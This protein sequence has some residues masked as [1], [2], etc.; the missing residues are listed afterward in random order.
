MSEPSSTAN[1]IHPPVSQPLTKLT[2]SLS[3]DPSALKKPAPKMLAKPL[4]KLKPTKPTL[5][6]VVP[7][8]VAPVATPVATPVAPAPVV[9]PQ[10]PLVYLIHD[11]CFILF[12]HSSRLLYLLLPSL[13]FR[14]I[15]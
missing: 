14:F 6:P 1:E 12:N 13:L 15:R 3:P 11:V 5:A 8:V 9:I 2:N 7:S 4:T 10:E